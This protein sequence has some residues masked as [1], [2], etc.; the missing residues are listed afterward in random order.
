MLITVD[1]GIQVGKRTASGDIFTLEACRE[2]M[3]DLHRLPVCQG[4]NIIGRVRNARLTGEHDM[5]P[6]RIILE[7]EVSDVMTQKAIGKIS[8]EYVEKLTKRNRNGSIARTMLS[9]LI[10]ETNEA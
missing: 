6:N 10:A 3:R 8:V 4:R 2:M 9:K 5:A 1:S 7:L